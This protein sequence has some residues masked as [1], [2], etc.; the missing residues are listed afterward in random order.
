MHNHKQDSVGLQTPAEL[1][2]PAHTRQQQGARHVASVLQEN[3]QVKRRQLNV[4]NAAR[5]LT[6]PLVVQCASAMEGF[7]ERV[8]HAQVLHSLKCVGVGVSIGVVVV[9][10]V[11]VGVG[12]MRMRMCMCMCMCM[13]VCK[14]GCVRV[15]VQV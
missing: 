4:T 8:I 9:V 5:I 15:R 12:V 13:C 3:L 10:G 1:V 2:P 7:P 6:R 11:G 14:Y